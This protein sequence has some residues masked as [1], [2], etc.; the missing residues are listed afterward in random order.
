MD[1]AQYKHFSAL[2]CCASN[3]VM[4]VEQVKRFID[5][6]KKMGYNMLELC[7]DDMYKIEDEPYFG[8]LRGGY[9]LAELREMDDYARSQ[10]VELIPAIQT[11]SHLNN[12]TKIPEF[13]QITDIDDILLVD[14]PKTYELIEK[15]FQTISQGFSSRLVNIGFDE[16]FRVGLGKYL[17]KNGYTERHE[18]LL[19]HLNRVTAIAH[20]YGFQVRMYSDMF[21]HSVPAGDRCCGADRQISEHVK[22]NIPENVSLCYWE[23]YHTDEE[24]YDQMLTAHEWFDRELWFAGGAWTWCGFAPHNSYALRSMGA[25]MKQVRKH[26]IQ[27]VTITC[28]G[29]SGHDNSYFT[30]LPTLYAIRQ[31]ADGNYDMDAIRQGFYERFGVRFD[32]FMLLE[33]PNLHRLNPDGE[34]AHN[35]C[36]FALYSDCFLGYRDPA[37]AEVLPIPFDQYAATL[38]QAQGRMGPYAYL[39]ENMAAFCDVMQ[40]KADLGI[41]TRSLYQAG[42]KAGLRALV[43]DYEET[44]RRLEAFRKT[45]RKVWMLE[46]KPYAWDIQQMRLGALK[47]RLEDC[48]DR[49]R[50]Y[51]E[52]ECDSIPELEETL[53]PYGKWTGQGNLY[54]LMVSV[55]E[56]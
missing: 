51:L 46:N 40:W 22:E 13:D 5:A 56:L 14:E 1:M 37:T 27:N 3:A 23:Y 25:A 41:R 29:D 44:I 20:K 4:K 11:L 2:I 10:G 54:R 31:F 32:D 49:L 15:M 52:G 24:H 55:S 34:T 47:A 16:A 26:G 38:R 8:Y 35:M 33:L 48:M 30:A 53:L 50:E 43:E 12:L 21:C 39:F 36:K 9:S 42:D 7:I 17:E 28:W 6:L 45:L 19:R 18:L